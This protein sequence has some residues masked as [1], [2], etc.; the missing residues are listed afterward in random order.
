MHNI[1]VQAYLCEVN[2]V[3]RLL[4]K[5]YDTHEFSPNDAEYCYLYT[6][7][8]QFLSY[9]ERTQLSLSPEVL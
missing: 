4:R 7:I 2:T 9:I 6:L 3:M 8:G 5:I 1:Q